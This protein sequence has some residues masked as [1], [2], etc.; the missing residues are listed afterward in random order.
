ML[1][2]KSRVIA[3]AGVLV[4]AA[5]LLSGCTTSTAGTASKVI[6]QADFDAAMK[7]PT[8]LTF[9]TW[10]PD[11]KNEVALFEAKYP[12]IHVNVENVGQGA[13]QYTKL[14]TALTAG[15][16]A[17]DVAQ[18]GFD[19][20]S[21]FLLTD[22]LLDLA[23]YGAAKLK[24]QYVPWV[25]DGVTRGDS[26]YGIPQDSGPM[27]NL[28]RDDLLKAAGITSAPSTW[29]EYAADAKTLKDK[30][31]VYISDL[32]PS[33]EAVIVGLM[34]QQG[35]RPFNF[36]G[37]KTVSIGVNGTDAKKVMAYWQKM[38]QSDLVSVEPSFTDAWYQGL[39]TGKYAGWLT[40]AWAPVF[41]NGIAKDT[42]GNW[43]AAPLPQ[44]SS[45]KPAAGNWGG[46]SDAVV[47]TTK[48][49]VAAYELARFINNEKAPAQMLAEKQFL[50][51]VLNSVVQDPAYLDT[52]A[53][54]YGG[55]QV[56]KVFADI[57]TTVDTNFNYLPFQDTVV[58][59]Y[60]DTVAKAIT[61]KGDLGAALDA[62][63]AALVS[64][65]KQQGF[66]VK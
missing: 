49:P 33:D 28:Y 62:W 55:Q 36:D 24:N 66:T 34:W 42:A 18:I 65:A 48:N 11:I 17:P 37:K 26:V 2:R 9:W 21:S 10:V 41:L 52:K 47:K 23:P 14:R 6:S 51:P 38:I 30:T 35:V 54:F 25:W 64:Y 22:S 50:F 16:G 5:S 19:Y 43:K 8:T 3:A 27:G 44:W 46:S 4:A 13:P 58:S 57:S 60:T 61:E 15:T 40:A 56:N 29:D 63:Q 39:A 1:S 32:S 59:T 31:G 53:A 45:S 7:K 20:T 12:A